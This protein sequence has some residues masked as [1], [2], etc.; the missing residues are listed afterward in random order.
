[1]TKRILGVLLVL[2]MLCGL[3]PAVLA[4]PSPI[5]TVNVTADLAY[6]L[7]G[8]KYNTVIQNFYIDTDYIYVTQNAGSGTF[9]LSRLKISG[10][11]ATYVDHMT[12][13]NCGNGESLAGYH[14]NGKL[15]FFI[16]AKGLEATNYGSTQ[17]ARIRYE[18][19]KSYTYTALNRFI[20]LS[21][22]TANG[23]S[24]G[25]ANRVAVAA[26]DLF[27]IF[28]IQTTDDSLTY[29]CYYTKNLNQALDAAQSVGME[30][31]TVLGGFRYSF[32][33][34]K[35]DRVIPN[36][37]FQGL[38]LANS[39][40]ILV[41]GGNSGETPAI[42]RMSAGGTYQYLANITNI[43]TASTGPIS[44]KGDR[45]Y[46]AYVPS[47][48]YAN[49]QKLYSFVGTKIGVPAV[50]YP[51]A[52][53]NYTLTG[54]KFTS[55]I[56]NFYIDSDYLYVTQSN[57]T[58]TQYLSRLKISGT[59][60]SYV[61]HMTLTECGNGESLAVYRYNGK[62]YFFVGAKGLEATSYHS[63]QIARVQYEPGK[64]YA[65][66][67]LNRFCH[68]SNS[69]AAGTN[70]GSAARV[71]VG[72][73]DHY[74]V[75]RIEL[76]DGTTCYTCYDTKAL[77]KALDSGTLIA[78][79]GTSV[80][81]GFIYHFKQKK[82]I[83]VIPNNSFQGV[84]L[85]GINNLLLSGGNSGETPAVAKMNKNGT[86]E[87]LAYITNIGTSAT[88]PIAY[89]ND[90]LYI[91][92]TG[93]NKIYSIGGDQL[94]IAASAAPAYSANAADV[95]KAAS[96][97]K[98]NLDAKVLPANVTI[99]EKSCTDEQFLE[100][101][102]RLLLNIANGTPNEA[103]PYTDVAAASS[104]SGTAVGTVAKEDYIAMA[105]NIL[106]NIDSFRRAPN[107][108]TSATIG[109]MQHSYCV[110]MYAFIL[111]YYVRYG[112]LPEAYASVTWAGTTA[113]PIAPAIPGVSALD[114]ASASTIHL[115]PSVYP[116]PETNDY[117]QNM[118]I[119]LRTIEGKTIV[120]DGGRKS[121]DS[122]YLFK[123]LQRVTGD[124]TP[125]VDAWFM[126]H[127][128]SD[129]HGALIG[130]ANKYASS[131]TVDAFYHR[132]PT[133][134]QVNKYFADV[135]PAATNTNIQSV[136]AAVGKLKNAK[137]GA[138]QQVTLNTI[139]SGKCNSTFDFD[140]VH[141][142]I[143]LTI[144]D[145]FWA[146]D[147]ISTKYTATWETHNANHQ[148]QAPKQLVSENFNNSSTVFRITVG[149]K[150]IM[151][152]GD[153]STVST[154]MLER[155][156]KAHASDSSKYYSLKTDM[157]Q[158][159]HHGSRR[160]LSQA[161]YQT[162]DPEAVLWPAPLANMLN[163]SISLYPRNW[164][165]AL[166]ATPYFSYQ[167]PQVLTFAPKRS[168]AATTISE[169]LK[170]LVFDPEYYAEK[171][172]ELKAA[173]GT[174]EAQLYKHFVNYGLE[175]GRCASPYFDVRFYMNNNGEQLREHCHGD[176]NVAFAHFVKYVSDANERKNNPKMLSPTFDCA[177]YGSAY[178]DTKA[179]TTELA[180]LQHF[181]TVGEAEGRAASQGFMDEKGITYHRKGTKTIVSQASCAAAGTV[182]YSCSDCGYSFTAQLPTT[183]HS[184]VTDG[185]VAPT[186][187]AAGL[188]EGSHCALCDRVLLP[189]ESIPATGHREVIDAAVPATCKE[190]GL[191]EG[192]HC[193]VCS[194]VLVAQQTVA[195]TEAHTDTDPVD[196]R[197]DVCGTR[198][199][200]AVLRFRTISLKGNIAINYYMDLSDEVAADE[201]AYMLFTME[202]GEEIRVPATQSERTLYQN[203]YY[204]VFT[205]AV[206]AK[207]M[208]DTVL[209]QFFY[210][211]GQTEVYSYSVKTYADRILAS[212]SSAKLRDL[213]Y[214]ML[215]YGAASQIHFEYHTDRLANAGL[216]VPDYTQ[217][218]I[219]GFPVN[220]K[221]GTSLATYAGASLLL[222]SETTLRIFF[223]VDSSVAEKFT[224]TYKGKLLPLGLRSG[225][226]YA[227]I[228]DISAKNLDDYFTLVI[229][230]GTESAEVSYAPLSYCASIIENAKGIHDRELQ[231]VAAAMY[232]Y[233]QAANAYFP[234]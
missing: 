52:T 12:L 149:G 172:P 183:E 214:A 93:N 31:A 3:A 186:C 215:N 64:T 174:D 26:N 144:D 190:S 162:I 209:C 142:D 180:L 129:H 224:V 11:T 210:E 178:A 44:V 84:E 110:Y 104:P 141:I 96:Y 59:T 61:D 7:K 48:D 78:M 24:V 122:D 117:Q 160:G 91:V 226:Y 21:S 56:Q 47:G 173:Y 98:A 168:A 83:R 37:S 212:S 66:T 65:Y 39:D 176:Y 169:E 231:D 159:A 103:L 225:K 116:D 133:E 134:A 27:T 1:M 2:A 111:D 20:H 105:R 18:A 191:T 92:C 51:S 138:V 137:G 157:V 90:R 72:A 88:G 108:T 222:T 113:A 229:H 150:T 147:N 154:I 118:S 155:Y 170:P 5:S 119:V 187:T 97:M 120:I 158:I 136:L 85:A 139:H 33:Q 60:A 114:L 94:G 109:K 146:V 67:D 165:A 193:E 50:T 101:A 177:Y 115:L 32:T 15:Y 100:L 46:I 28:R 112:M 23:T 123:Y 19:G 79:E 54:L 196:N 199:Q 95:L 126:T 30:T 10:K 140:D 227:D 102:C 204:Y 121:Y 82:S 156:H 77:N 234:Q 230:D 184:P 131:I 206:S 216:T 233:N 80:R 124:S 35:A 45:V 220:T 8:L 135:D 127:A 36:N 171:Y 76:D 14:Y 198:L 151:I 128:H 13:T 17:I 87:R 194:E 75:F 40:M 89:L 68:L 163:D 211:G 219:D 145:I 148:N 43:G 74:T 192:K 130:I 179:L 25:S 9:Y 70:L 232:L 185:A 228:P 107:Y 221:Q 217:V 81:S 41:S 207:E 6:D 189:Q 55:V 175:E 166:G 99:G 42:A 86:Y 182:K 208:A 62:L 53:L 34:A 203:A 71:A 57:T 188:T 218:T 161:I 125:H 205:C 195:P 22:S 63:T 201:N 200:A 132:F 152:T 164:I 197:C 73:N 153:A 4:A 202:D 49:S 143:L 181:V 29:S 38:E 69:T 58:G 16:G 213:I 167:G 106:A 223:T